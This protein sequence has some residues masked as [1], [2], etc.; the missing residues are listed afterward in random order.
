M[1]TPFPLINK[2]A[3]RTIQGR[4]TEV[5]VSSFHD[6]I[7]ILV[8]QYG[9]V[10]SVIHTTLDQQSLAP[11]SS[12]TLA[13]T[14]SSFLLGA[15]SSTSKKTQLY[16][17]YA[18]HIS[19]MIVHQN[20]HEGRP[21]VLSLALSIQEPDMEHV[22]AQQEQRQLDRDLFENVIDMVNECCVW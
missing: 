1:E 6:K 9:K 4:H 12:S 13:P 2:Q 3:A 17:V 14:S 20:P 19:Q 18:S 10:G 22:S 8:S 21:V 11:T 5:L 15:G 16:Q 7:L